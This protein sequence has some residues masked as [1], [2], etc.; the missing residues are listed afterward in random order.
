MIVDSRK[1]TPG[2]PPPPGTLTVLE[3]M[4]GNIRVADRTA[5]LTGE[6]AGG[7]PPPWGAGLW[8]SYN[9]PSD[10]F[11]FAISGQQALVDK[12]G[13]A[14]GAGAYFTWLNT[15]R[16]EIFRRQGGAVVD[17][18]STAA[19]IRY[20]EFTTDPVAAMGCGARPPYSACNA[21]ADRSDLNVKG[22]DYT[23]P[24]LGHGDSAAIDAKVVS[25]AWLTADRLA[26]GD[27]TMAAQSGPTITAS[28]PMFAFSRG[29]VK[30][31]HE[32]YP[33]AFNFSWVRVEGDMNVSEG[34]RLL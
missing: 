33:D 15:S 26:R 34:L 17:V 2:A 30:A 25:L 21:I 9:V 7:Q 3:E 10:P 28:C 16:A 1:F 6:P 24:G 31:A 14:S 11:I 4:P 13:G 29:S 23:I 18:A 20:N 19:L 22:G 12:Y 27:L 5:A 8:A 32:G